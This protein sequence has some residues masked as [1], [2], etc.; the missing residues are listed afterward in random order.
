[1]IESIEPPQNLRI[2]RHVDVVFREVDARLEQRDQVHQFL[3]GE[4][5]RDT[6]P[7]TCCAATRAW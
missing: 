1:M 7:S 4:S 6:D 3:I 5:R 2:R